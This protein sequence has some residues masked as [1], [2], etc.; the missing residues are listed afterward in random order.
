TGEG[1]VRRRFYTDGDLAVFSF[2]RCIILTGIDLGSLNGDLADRLLPVTLERIE[3]SER[4]TEE[5][6]WADWRQA[7]PRLLG[8]VLNLAASVASILPTLELGTLPRMAG[9]A[10]ILAAVDQLLGTNG[11]GH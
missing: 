4:M 2:R 3:P 11:Y 10:R 6:I 5:T 9:Y 8:A 7:H 1:D